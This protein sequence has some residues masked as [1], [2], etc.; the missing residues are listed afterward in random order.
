[1]NVALFCRADIAKWLYVSI[2]FRPLFMSVYTII[3]GIA[4]FGPSIL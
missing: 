2:I 1:M 3:H 4:I